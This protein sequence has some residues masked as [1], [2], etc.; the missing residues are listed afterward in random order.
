M[1]AK[2]SVV[3]ISVLANRV[4]FSTLQ[5]QRPHFRKIAVRSAIDGIDFLTTCSR[6]E[7]YRARQYDESSLHASPRL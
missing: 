3:T 4:V 5:I 7:N 6:R 1:D 2:Q